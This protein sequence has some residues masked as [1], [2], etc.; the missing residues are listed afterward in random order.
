MGN[1]I[2]LEQIHPG[3]IHGS[4]EGYAKRNVLPKEIA[5]VVTNYV[6]VYKE[7]QYTIEPVDNTA[8]VLVFINGIGSIELA[9]HVYKIKEMAIFVPPPT[10]PCAIKSAACELEF[11]EILMDFTAT[12]VIEMDK[13]AQKYSYFAHYS[14]CTPYR[15][16]IKSHKTVSRT[17]LPVSIVPRLTI[18][19]VKTTGPDRVRSHK[20]PML[21]QLFYGLPENHCYVQ[22]DAHEQFFGENTLLHIPLGS[23]H[24][25]K[26]EKE[27]TLHYLWID[28]FQDQK[29]MSYITDSHIPIDDS[30]GRS[31]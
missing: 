5:G 19:S 13:V 27:S 31:K 15:E 20:H 11:L 17:L 16:A 30:M 23:M 6:R 26:V 2:K 24:S 28:F 12:D 22:A 10:P 3:R 14:E 29:D 9:A 8:R 4:H 21:E 7:R 18:G 25:V 1:Y